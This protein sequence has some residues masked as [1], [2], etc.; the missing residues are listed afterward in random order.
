MTNFTYKI[1]VGKFK[2]N[3]AVGNREKRE[4]TIRKGKRGGEYNQNIFYTCMQM[5]L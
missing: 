2:T 4:E 1:H 3:R 5:S